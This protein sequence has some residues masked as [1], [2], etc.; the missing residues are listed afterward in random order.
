MALHTQ[1]V[2]EDDVVASLTQLRKLGKDLHANFVKQTLQQTTLPITNTLKRQKILTIANRP[3]TT[4]KGATSAGAHKNSSLITKLFLFLQSRP[5][6][7]IEFFC[8]ENQKEPPSLS[9]HGSLR[10]GSKSDILEC[11]NA[12]TA[13][14]AESKTATVVVLDMAA[15][16]HMVRPCSAHNFTDYVS[17]SLMPFVQLQVTPTVTRV[18]AIWDTYPEDN[19][20]TLTHQRRGLGARTQIGDGQT[21]IPKED[22]NTGFLKNT[23][24]KR[25]LFPFLGEQLVKQ[26]L[27]GKLILSTSNECV[28]SNSQYDVAALQP[29]NHAEA[30]TR[31]MLHLAHAAKQGHQV[32]LVRTVDSDVVVLAIRFFSSL[33][34]SQLWVCLGSGKKIRDITIHTLSAQLGPEKCLALPLFHAVTGC[35]TASQFLGC[36]KKSVWLAW[37]S[38]PGLTDTFVALTNEPHSDI[39]PQS[40]YMRTLE[41]F[42][43]V[44]YSKSCGLD[45]VNEARL[46]LFT[47][48]KKTLEA[49]P[50]TQAA[51]CQHIRRA[52]TQSCFFW[53]QATSVH[54][55]IPDL[56]DWGWHLENRR[57]LPFWTHLHDS[58]KACSILLHCG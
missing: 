1:Q 23:D 44:M 47:S 11:L 27:D 10:S 56:H 5:D 19:L 25:E 17:K 37:Q 29:C 28:L 53:N 26:K 16:V 8:Y 52:I 4:K 21:R 14:S 20:K 33:G 30:D 31:I 40:Q 24:N 13:R 42:V 3:V 32:A 9:N 18:D 39:S 35:D 34:L 22:W 51:L 55:D 43:V 50:P 12:P 45:S 54:Q 38:T 41:R 57:W 58:S 36:G 7:D 49:L 15:V 46:R 6:A 2:M 48:G